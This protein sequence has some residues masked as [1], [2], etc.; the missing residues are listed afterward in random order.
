M[1]VYMVTITETLQRKVLVP[2]KSFK[3][4]EREV[5][6]R[7]ED[8]VYVLGAEDFKGVKYDV[9]QKVSAF[10]YDEISDA[11]TTGNP[12]SVFTAIGEVKK[13]LRERGESTDGY[14]TYAKNSGLLFDEKGHIIKKEV[15]A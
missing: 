7:W 3:E 15:A 1:G 6:Y 2:A 9:W 4:A 14:E 13:L 5:K 11:L 12:E 10:T 8:G